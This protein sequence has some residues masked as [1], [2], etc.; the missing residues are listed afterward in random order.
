MLVTFRDERCKGC[1]HCI[2]ACPKDIIG[3]SEKLNVKGYHMATITEENMPKCIAC[4]SCA[5]VCP[6]LVIEVEK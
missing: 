6:D 3:F 4:A 5:I 2:N 1:G